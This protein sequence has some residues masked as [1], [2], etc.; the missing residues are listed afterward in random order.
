MC[1]PGTL[2]FGWAGGGAG[3]KGRGGIAGQTAPRSPVLFE[4]TS[5]MQQRPQEK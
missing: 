1:K 2:R 3:Q 5:I 4:K